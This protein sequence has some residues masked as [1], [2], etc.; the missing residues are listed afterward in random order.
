LRAK[1]TASDK[2]FCWSTAGV[3]LTFELHNNDD[4]AGECEKKSKQHDNS[5][6][7]G[8]AVLSFNIV[9]RVLFLPLLLGIFYFYSG[10]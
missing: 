1:Q 2:S 9:I 8:D 5:S 4:L 3:C 10:L 6:C 7:A